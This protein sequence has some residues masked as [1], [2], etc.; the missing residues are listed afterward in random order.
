M[1]VAGRFLDDLRRLLQR[2]AGIKIER[3]SDCWEL[4]LVINRRRGVGALN[5][6]D[7]AERNLN[8]GRAGNVNFIKSGWI[9]KILWQGLQDD[10]ELVAIVVDDRNL[11][12]TEC[13]I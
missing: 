8:V 6:R 12:L 4:A 2:S 7:G 5:V 1:D 13:T 3:E 10:M 9:R 11:S